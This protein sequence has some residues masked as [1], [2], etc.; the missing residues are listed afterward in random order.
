MKPPVNLAALSLRELQYAAAVNQTRHFGQAAEHCAVSQAGLSEQLRKLEEALGGP[1]FERAYRR[2]DLTPRGALLLPQ[3]DRILTEARALMTLA[4]SPTEPM[5]FPLRL[6]AIATLG[7]YYLPHLLRE[8]R[9]AFAHLPLRLSESRTASLL[10][11][12]R[13]GALDAA[14]LALPLPMAGLTVSAL[15][16]EPFHLVCPRQHAMARMTAPRLADLAGA[17]LILLEEGHCLRDQALD[18]CGDTD[19]PGRQAT[20]IETLWH[21][22][23]SGEGYSLLPALSAE[24]REAMTELVACRPIPEA[25]AGRTIGL[26]W[27]AT[28]PRAPEYVRLAATLR[29]GLPASVRPARDWHHH[30]D[31]A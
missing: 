2:V 30:E 1:L 10:D 25:D 3:I 12:L 17:D 29:A 11:D 19:R 7:P 28:D 27:R 23:A 21:M 20:S 6:G 5:S 14:L 8:V 15:F 22:I 13:A 4:H 26:V 18:L 31:T 24:G 9:A 16:F